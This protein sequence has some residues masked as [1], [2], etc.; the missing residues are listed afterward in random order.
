MARA[1][2]GRS[3]EGVHAVSAA[4]HA[5]R[6]EALKVEEARLAHPDVA[7]LV[8]LAGR[9]SVPVDVV[10]DVRA[11]ATTTAPQGVV[12]TARPL[13]TLGLEEAV[14]RHDPAALLVID[15]AEDPRNV[16]AAVRS[17]A[18]A[19]IGAVVL[20]ERRAAPLG[21]TAFKAAAGAFEHVGVVVVSSIADAVARLRRLGVWVV[22]LDAGA[23]TSLFGL[24]GLVEPVAI[25][26][27]A[28]ANGLSRLVAERA[29]ELVRIP[30]AAG[31]ES[32]NASVA[33][34]VAVFEVA[35][36]RGELG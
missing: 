22:G 20:S 16:G 33:A 24:D 5:G 6:V 19:G 9:G 27:G 30:L 29:D 36:A 25:V 28:E 10:E 11:G 17:A 31:I 21:P 3:L 12:A 4:L 23:P 35:R 2:I 13:E 18:A 15:R 1:G 8:A 14:A 34:A 7:A 32:L 26:V